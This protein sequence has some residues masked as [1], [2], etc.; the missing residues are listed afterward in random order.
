MDP[1]TTA[2]TLLPKAWKEDKTLL[3]ARNVEEIRLR[4]GYRPSILLNGKEQGF[5][6]ELVDEGILRRVMEIATGASMHTA[7][8]ALAE[9]YVSYQGL[10]IGVCGVA[11]IH[12]GLMQGFRS[13]SS[14]AVR[15]PRECKGI[16][17]KAAETL[18]RENL[19]STL[20]I[21][22]PGAGKTTA[23]RDLVRSL[24][25]KGIRIG[26]ADER[27]E[28]AA[29][30]RGANGFDLGPCTDVITGI[31]KEE[32]SMMLLRGMNPQMIAM[33]EVTKEAD[34]QAVQQISGCGVGILATAHGRDLEEIRKRSAYRIMLQ[35]GIFRRCMQIENVSGARTYTLREI[36]P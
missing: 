15:I 7:A 9:G 34:L 18:M 5:C 28:L 23:L 29:Q 26:V 25:E 30:E 19:P 32:G 16:C 24:S 12:N 1:W 13:L 11:V 35:Q 4:R 21:G 2:L 17:R 20:L 8:P 22:T 10:R 14:L 33:D 3:N 27:N 36:S 6:S 31:G